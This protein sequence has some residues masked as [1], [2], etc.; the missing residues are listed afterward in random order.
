MYVLQTNVQIFITIINFFIY[1]NKNIRIK[2]LKQN[3]NIYKNIK[4]SKNEK[5]PNKR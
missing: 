5:L 3:G 4:E 2:K 1:K